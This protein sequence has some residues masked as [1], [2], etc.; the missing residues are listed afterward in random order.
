MANVSAQEG[1]LAGTAGG[2]LLTIAATIHPE[3]VVKTVILA[4]LG[5]VTSFLISLLIKWLFRKIRT[6]P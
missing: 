4:T 3:D 5:A 1:T 2:T 6:P